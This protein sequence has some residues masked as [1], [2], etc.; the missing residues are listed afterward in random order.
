VVATP[1][2][3]FE[4]IGY[5]DTLPMIFID[6]P[7][8]DPTRLAG[9]NA[10]NLQLLIADASLDDARVPASEPKADDDSQVL[11]DLHRL[12]HKVNVLIQL[13]AK[14]VARE[15]SMPEAVAWRLYATGIEWQAETAPAT[16]GSAGQVLIYVS[17]QFPQPLR[18]PGK[19]MPPRHDEAGTWQGF[20]FEGLSVA[21]TEGLERLIFRHHRRAVAGVRTHPRD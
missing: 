12:E 8:A 10:D 4:G 19:I 17:R 1:A 21:V 2:A 5:A 3:A 7:V 15:Q 9:L 11:E 20:A 14:L 18:F 6:E 16:P 13:V